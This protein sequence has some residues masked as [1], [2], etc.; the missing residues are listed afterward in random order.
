MIKKRIVEEDIFTRVEKVINNK[1]V[2]GGPKPLKKGDKINK[3]KLI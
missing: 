2:V 3:D 1:P